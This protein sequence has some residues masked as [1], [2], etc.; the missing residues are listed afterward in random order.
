M[1]YCGSRYRSRGARRTAHFIQPTVARSVGP[2]TQR[3]Y[4]AQATDHGTQPDGCAGLA[5]PPGS[6]RS[7]LGA[8]SESD[9]RW[10]RDCPSVVV[11][12]KAL[13]LKP[14]PP[15][16]RLL[17]AAGASASRR[18]AAP[19]PA[20]PFLPT[21][22]IIVA[23]RTPSSATSR[24]PPPRIQRTRRRPHATRN[25]LPPAALQRARSARRAT[26]PLPP[27]T[28]SMMPTAI[29]PQT[30]SPARRRTRTSA[31][32]QRAPRPASHAARS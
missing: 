5:L 1:I 27:Q 24:S 3:C 21:P 28:R 22:D 25:L 11:G 23:I 9:G 20:L 18:P 16:V 2:G 4:P 14:N 19:S 29:S 7:S 17:L 26:A 8:D 6:R 30:P 13:N 31:P 15:E 12:L 32:T 10:P